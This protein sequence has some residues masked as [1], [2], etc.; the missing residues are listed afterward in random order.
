MS[1]IA[2]GRITFPC[3]YV[4]HSGQQYAYTQIPLRGQRQNHGQIDI[5]LLTDFPFNLLQKQQAPV[6]CADYNGEN[7]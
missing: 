7:G 5:G 6:E 1:T 2:G 3:S 4:E